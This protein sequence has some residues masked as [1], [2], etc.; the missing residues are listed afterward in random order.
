[1]KVS[2]ATI[3]ALVDNMN[4]ENA[5]LKELGREISKAAGEGGFLSKN[6]WLKWMRKK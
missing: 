5:S 2:C 4:N 6:W 1:M 3:D